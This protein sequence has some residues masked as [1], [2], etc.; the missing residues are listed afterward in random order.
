MKPTEPVDAGD[1]CPMPDCDGTVEGK[2]EPVRGIPGCDT[3]GRTLADPEWRE[4][5]EGDR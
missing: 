3:C 2:W 1:P 4:A 5:A